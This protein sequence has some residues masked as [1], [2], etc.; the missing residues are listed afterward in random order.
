MEA[1]YKML[2]RSNPKEAKRLMALAQEDV[3]K[4][5]EIYERLAQEGTT[6]QTGTEGL[7]EADQMK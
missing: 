1:R 2:T 5:R 4:R 3:D 6:A 7:Q